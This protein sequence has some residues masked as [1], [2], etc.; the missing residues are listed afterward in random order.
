MGDELPN[1]LVVSDSSKLEAVPGAGYDI[2][3][4]E[5]VKGNALLSKVSKVVTGAQLFSLFQYLRHLAQAA[6]NAETI[7]PKLLL[8][9]QLIEHC[10][11]M[12]VLYYCMSC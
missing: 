3:T 8:V 9:A 1:G 4:F 2:K 12:L 6:Q 5:E 7:I 11:F 10:R